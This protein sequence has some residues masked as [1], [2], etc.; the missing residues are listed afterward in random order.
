MSNLKKLVNEIK[1]LI[2]NEDLSEIGKLVL[3]DVNG[4]EVVFEEATLEDI[5]V[6]TKASPDGE[7]TFIDNMQVKIENGE[8]VE[9]TREIEVPEEVVNQVAEEIKNEGGEPEQ[10]PSQEPAPEQEPEQEPSS[11]PDEKDKLI[12]ELQTKVSELT[13]QLEA[14]TSQLQEAT[15]S[16]EEKQAEIEEV[17]N[18]LSEIKNFYTKVTGEASRSSVTV[19][20]QKTEKFEGFRFSRK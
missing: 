9:V 12:E 20:P 8:V 19:E 4:T 11:E 3:S 16:A 5:H 6:G 2:K 15:K 14:I 7:F 18:E 17:S 10:E 13:G 1:S